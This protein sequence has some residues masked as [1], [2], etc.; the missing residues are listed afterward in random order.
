MSQDNT[1][2]LWTEERVARL[3]LAAYPGFGSR[4]L[5]KLWRRFS[6]PREAWLASPTGLIE[7]GVRKKSAEH[8][9]DWRKTFDIAKLLNQLEQEKIRV[10]FRDDSAFPQYLQTAND[11]PEILFIRGN[12]VDI[13]AIAIVGTRRITNYGRQCV[14]EIVPD[15][16]RTGLTIVSGMALGIDGAVHQATINAQGVTIAILG[17]GIDDASLYPREHATLGKQILESGGAIIS[18]FPP[19]TGSRKENFPIRNRLIA[20]LALA[21]LVIEADQKSGSLITAKLALEENREVLAVPGPIWSAQSSGA[22]ALLK[23]GAKVCT[24]A[25]DVLEALAL[26]QPTLIGQ[27]RA[28]LPLDLIEQQILELLDEPTHI[29]D[30]TTAA[31]SSPATISAKVA[32]LEMK[33]LIK[34]IGGQMWI[35]IRQ[36]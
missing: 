10:L 27:A 12:L 21:T 18:E 15:L 31:E 14:N 20:S 19:G 26:D 23:S 33:G 4:S 11:P 36:K 5:R 24:C 29:D 32:L 13:P 17:T 28:S 3:C 2:P 8:F 35:K 25:A 16:A 34:P 7:S 9:V 30:I 1:S 22:N 6:D